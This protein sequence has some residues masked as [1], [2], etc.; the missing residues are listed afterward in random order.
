MAGNTMWGGG[1]YDYLMGRWSRLLAPMLARFA[2]CA[3]G[4]SILDIGCV[5]IHLAAVV[6]H[7]KRACTGA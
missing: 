2:G 5:P 1:D 4:E 7:T 3:D 6:T